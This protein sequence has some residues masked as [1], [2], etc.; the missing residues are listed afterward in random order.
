VETNELTDEAFEEEMRSVEGRKAIRK[1]LGE[2]GVSGWG[3]EEWQV[4]RRLGRMYTSL[5]NSG[6]KTKGPY[7]REEDDVMREQ[8]EIFVKVFTPVG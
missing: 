5:W 1:A 3:R 4:L 2:Y 7:S 8:I 6:R